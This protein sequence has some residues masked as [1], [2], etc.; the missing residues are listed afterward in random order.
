MKRLFFIGAVLV[1]TLN[2]NSQNTVAK[3]KF[4]DAEKAY[5][6]NKFEDCIQLLTE[7]EALL[8]QTA[9][10]ILHLGI[11]AEHKLL[12]Q[13]PMHSYALIENLRNHCNTYLQDY[14][15]AGLE[16]K[17]R[18]VFE[19]SNGLKK[20]PNDILEFNAIKDSIA[21]VKKEAYDKVVSIIEN[22]LNAIGGKEKLSQVRSIHKIITL[23]GVSY[24]THEKFLFPDKFAL[25][26]SRSETGNKKKGQQYV[27]N[28]NEC[29]YEIKGEKENLTAM[30]CKS[31]QSNIN[32]NSFAELQ[33]FNEGY[34]LQYYGENEKGQAAILI[35]YPDATKEWRYYNLKTHL[36]ETIIYN[37]GY[38]WN[39]YPIVQ[40]ITDLSDYREVEGV[41][42]PFVYEHSI[43][44][45][46]QKARKFVRASKIVFINKNVNVEDFN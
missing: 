14:D 12:E 43:F 10:N 27:Y 4:E 5:Y 34:D 16:E 9:P 46:N 3:F 45:D 32:M 13:N 28:G 19:V 36:L 33:F 35:T 40:T 24:D 1:F 42:L 41:I 15:I 17:F 25:F 38:Y 2:V 29:Y 39:Y 6:E 26:G 44:F 30:T 37:G 7:T 11:L 18:E 22:Y 21:Q 8:G 31:F 20:Y 23:K